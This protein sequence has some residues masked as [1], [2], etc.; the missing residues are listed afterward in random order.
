MV[1]RTHSVMNA[2][3]SDLAN[4]IRVLPRVSIGWPLRVPLVARDDLATKHW[5]LSVAVRVDCHAAVERLVAVIVMCI[6]WSS[7]LSITLW[8]WWI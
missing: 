5:M 8:R 4:S 1:P 2:W 7:W 6:D 3:R